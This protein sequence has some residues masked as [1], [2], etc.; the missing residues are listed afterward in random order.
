MTTELNPFIAQIFANLGY[1]AAAK[2]AKNIP[3]SVYEG[4]LAYREFPRDT[5]P[6]P[7]Y[8]TI[9]IQRQRDR[10]L[11]KRIFE[12]GPREIKTCAEMSRQKLETHL[13]GYFCDLT[14]L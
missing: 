12:K 5:K 4:F 14:Q 1:T 13:R 9:W 7:T 11:L 10:G 2:M 3:D 6:S 8:F